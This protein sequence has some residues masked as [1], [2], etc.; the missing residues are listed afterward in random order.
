MHIGWKVPEIFEELLEL[1][2]VWVRLVASEPA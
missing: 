2:A 1:R